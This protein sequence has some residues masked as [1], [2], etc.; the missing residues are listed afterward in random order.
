MKPQISWKV[1]GQQGEGIES[2]GEIFA[3]ESKRL[4]F[5]WIS[6]FLRS[7]IKGGHTNNKI[8]VSTSPVHAISDDLDMHL[9]KDN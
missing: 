3:T 6:T 7:R 8:R 9:I 2:T 1:G 4:L 5:I